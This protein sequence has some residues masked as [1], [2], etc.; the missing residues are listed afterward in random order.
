MQIL[1]TPTIWQRAIA[2]RLVVGISLP[3]DANV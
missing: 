2:I 1:F 3:D